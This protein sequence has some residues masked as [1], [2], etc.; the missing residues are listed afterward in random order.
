MEVSSHAADQ[1]RIAGLHFVGGVFTNLTR[2]HLDYHKTLRGEGAYLWLKRRSFSTCF[3]LRHSPLTNA[4][5]KV[6]EVM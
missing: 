3:R 5:D 1:Q 4:D 6:G 2:D